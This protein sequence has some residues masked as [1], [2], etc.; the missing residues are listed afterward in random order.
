MAIPVPSPKNWMKLI[1][2]K[3]KTKKVTQ[4]NAAA[5]VTMGPL[6]VSPP[7]IARAR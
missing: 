7:T 3:P 1:F 5:V 2:E 4:S 6:R